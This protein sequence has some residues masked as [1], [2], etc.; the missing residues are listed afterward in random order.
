MGKVKI[1]PTKWVIKFNKLLEG[2]T[3]ISEFNLN[4]TQEFIF[5]FYT[6]PAVA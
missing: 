1:D 6:Q 3:K 5:H 2:R 4:A